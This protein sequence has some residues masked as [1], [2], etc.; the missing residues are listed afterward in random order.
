MSITSK[1]LLN[2]PT[3]S[4]T[5]FVSTSVSK[6]KNENFPNTSESNISVYS[7]NINSNWT[8]SKKGDNDKNISNSIMPKRF[9]F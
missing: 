9:V 7:R 6:N 4:I 1:Y 8:H 3:C 2:S 5:S